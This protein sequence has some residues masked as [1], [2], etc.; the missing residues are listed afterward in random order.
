MFRAD[1]EYQYR[2]WCMFCN[3]LVSA[4]LYSTS[5]IYSRLL[6]LLLLQM[7]VQLLLLLNV[8]WHTTPKGES[9]RPGFGLVKKKKSQKYNAGLDSD[10]SITLAQLDQVPAGFRSQFLACVNPYC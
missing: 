2:G 9:L 7:L 1:L 6:Q 3:G 8:V 10:F 4:V 5:I